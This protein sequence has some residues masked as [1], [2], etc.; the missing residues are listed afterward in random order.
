MRLAIAL[1]VATIVAACA[2]QQSSSERS[3][4][5]S[6]AGR[7]AQAALDAEAIMQGMAQ[8]RDANERVARDS[9]QF[10]PGNKPPAVTR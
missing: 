9:R 4:V 3:F 5:R 6:G 7:S 10:A 1:V 2:I 8:A